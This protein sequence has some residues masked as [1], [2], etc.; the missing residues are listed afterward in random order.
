MV[1]DDVLDAAIRRDEHK[2]REVRVAAAAA[3]EDQDIEEQAAA[4]S[5]KAEKEV[6]GLLGYMH[7]A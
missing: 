7:A 4:A 5:A 1:T 3:R 2:Y 6:G